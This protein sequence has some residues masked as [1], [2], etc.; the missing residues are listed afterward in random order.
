M[1]HTIFPPHRW[2]LFV[3]R[4]FI[5]SVVTSVAIPGYAGVAPDSIPDPQTIVSIYSFNNS[6]KKITIQFTIIAHRQ[7]CPLKSLK[8]VINDTLY[9][10]ISPIAVVPA[11]DSIPDAWDVTAVFPYCDHFTKRDHLILSTLS[12]DM[13]ARF[14]HQDWHFS[15]ARPEHSDV[16]AAMPQSTVSVLWIIALI[17]TVIGFGVW[18]YFRQR[19]ER[20]KESRRVDALFDENRRQNDETRRQNEE[21]RSKIDALYAGR[22]STL[23]FLCDEYYNKRDAQQEEVRMSMYK[24]VEKQ[25]LLLRSPKALAELENIV[26][27]YL[28]NIL[29]RLRQQIPSLTQ[30]EIVFLTYLYAGFSPRAVCIFCDIKIKNFYNRR[31]RLRARILESG[32]PDAEI[33]A[34]RM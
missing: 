11:T 34:S 13:C 15:P 12:G 27:T 8:A 24:E 22:V 6:D 23:N 30:N 26:N 18:I 2:L 20:R 19:I 17:L 10:V 33:F 9:S 16:P 25:I 3:C 14:P 21:L 31:S 32:A 1:R 4:M 28:N 29:M 5:T 7:E